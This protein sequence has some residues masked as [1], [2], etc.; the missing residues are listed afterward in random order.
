MRKAMV[1]EAL[2]DLSSLFGHQF[3]QC[4]QFNSSVLSSIE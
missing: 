3:K 2:Y 4:I 1:E